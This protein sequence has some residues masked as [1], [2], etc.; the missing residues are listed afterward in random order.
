MKIDRFFKDAI[1]KAVRFHGGQVRV[2][3][4]FG[5]SR[6]TISDLINKKIGATITDETKRKVIPLIKDHFPKDYPI[7]KW[8]AEKEGMYL[9]PGDIKP[10]TSK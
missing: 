6:S 5:I 3:D 1:K 4:K 7:E 2:S 9:R 10:V 8:L